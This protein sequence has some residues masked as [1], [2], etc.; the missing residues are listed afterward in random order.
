FGIV[1]LGLRLSLG[2]VGKISMIGLP[3]IIICMATALLL[4]TW[5]SKGLGLPRR[6]GTLIAVGTSICGVSAVVATAPIIGSED[7]EVSYSL[8]CI[9]LF[10]L[11]ALLGYP[12][13]AH[14]VF[15]DNAKE[16]GIFL[17]TAIHDTAQ[18][19]GAGLMYQQQFAAPAAL[20]TATVTKLVRNT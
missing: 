10:G 12:W 15:G 9:A 17:G 3:I 1:L 18:V 8:R 4:V 20:D 16:A 11:M 5:I 6:L 13:L 2:D 19:A 7:G 14:A